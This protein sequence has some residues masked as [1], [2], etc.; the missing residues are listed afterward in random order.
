[1]LRL[2]DREVPKG[3]EIHMILNNYSTHTHEDVRAWLDK[4]Q[5]FDLH[6]TPTSSS[7]PNP[8]ERW[9]RE[10]T[11]KR[12]RRGSFASVAELVSAIHGYIADNNEN[13]R[14][15]S[16]PRPPSRSSPRFVARRARTRSSPTIAR[17]LGVTA[18][19]C[20]PL[21]S[22]DRSSPRELACVPIDVSWPQLWCGGAA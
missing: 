22:D 18:L 11:T 8:M 7:W 3:T 20:A 16:G 17:H 10:I 12:I 2:I 4:H 15:S 9:F 6:C 14:P 21:G 1:L 5:R 13:P 19:R